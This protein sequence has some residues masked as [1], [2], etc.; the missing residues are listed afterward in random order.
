MAKRNW[1][2]PSQTNPTVSEEEQATG[3]P[4]PRSPRDETSPLRFPLSK[5]VESMRGP[6]I[7]LS[8]YKPARQPVRPSRGRARSRLGCGS[9][10]EDNPLRRVD[11][12]V[13]VGGRDFLRPVVL[14]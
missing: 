14:R 2:V 13:L 10:D 1:D 7:A 9:R 3:Q 6:S 5:F 12:L 4:A 8:V 11:V